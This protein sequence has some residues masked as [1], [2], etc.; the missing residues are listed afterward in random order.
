MAV[1]GRFLVE[2]GKVNA[3]S[4]EKH[5]TAPWEKMKFSHC[6]KKALGHLLKWWWAGK[7]QYNGEGPHHLAKVA[8]Y[9][10]RIMVMERKHRENDDRSVHK[11]KMTLQFV[12]NI[13]KTRFE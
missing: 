7:G 8:W 12:I 9:A 13:V 5:P 6:F 2:I 1:D 11:T 4:N 3:R 10:D